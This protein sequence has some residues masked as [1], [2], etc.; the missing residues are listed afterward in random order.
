MFTSGRKYYLNT[1]LIT[2]D[3][4]ADHSKITRE[5]LYDKYGAVLLSEY[6]SQRE[7]PRYCK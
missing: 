4:M 7:K 3:P 2:P 5:I 6:Y 1:F